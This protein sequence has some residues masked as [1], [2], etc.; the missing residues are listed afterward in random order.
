[1]LPE[2][3]APLAWRPSSIEADAKQHLC[4]LRPSLVYP[5]LKELVYTGEPVAPGTVIGYIFG[6]IHKNLP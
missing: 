6:R 3:N 5:Q 2:A 4:A 1:V